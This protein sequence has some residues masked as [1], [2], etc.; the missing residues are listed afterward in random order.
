MGSFDVS[1][2]RGTTI[3]NLLAGGPG[4]G[5]HI[6][7]TV[8]S[9]PELGKVANGLKE[10]GYKFNRDKSDAASGRH[11]F[12]HKDGSRVTVM[13]PPPK[14]KASA[15]DGADDDSFLKP[16][17]SNVKTPSFKAP[18]QLGTKKPPMIARSV[19]QSERKSLAKKGD[20]LKDGSFPIKNKKDLGNAKQAIGR[21]KH[22]E[23]ARR[24]INKRAKQ[25]GAPKLGASR[26]K[27]RLAKMKVRRGE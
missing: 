20:A 4:S 8:K 23:A 14:L 12:S 25:L 18:K 24:L 10:K 15:P 1:I 17:I 9:N 27:D 7:T 16:Q 22:P 21:S 3:D 11:E 26:A 19:K 2:P 6:T 5:R 13:Y